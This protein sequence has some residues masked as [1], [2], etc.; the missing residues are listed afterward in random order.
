MSRGKFWKLAKRLWMVLRTLP[1]REKLIAIYCMTEQTNRVGLFH[2][3]S[4]KAAEDLGLSR[5]AFDTA[6]RRVCDELAWKF[7]SEACVLYLTDWW[8]YN[9]PG[10]KDALRAFLRD[11]LDIPE[12]LLL[13]EFLS[14]TSAL[15]PELQTIFHDAVEA[16]SLPHCPPPSPPGCPPP[17]PQGGG[18][19]RLN[20]TK[21]RQDRD[22][23]PPVVSVVNDGFE[24]FWKAYPRKDDRKDALKAWAKLAP[25]LEL[26]T[27]ILQA[28][29]RQAKSSQWLK[30]RGEFI[31]LPATWLNKRRWENSGVSLN[32]GGSAGSTLCMFQEQKGLKNGRL[33]I[34]GPCG[35]LIAAQEGVEKPRPLCEG[36]LKAERERLAPRPVGP[37][38]TV[39]TMTNGCGLLEKTSESKS[40]PQKTG[41]IESAGI[42]G[43]G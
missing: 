18:H 27:Q 32:N 35:R 23:T 41:A 16:L 10:N 7:D 14:Q 36:H 38:E 13:T 31:P 40:S 30:D 11:L 2:F 8:Q 26:Q 34:Y 22:R 6:F 4:A 17:G 39:L 37:I 28:V 15:S 1:E 9:D 19:T 24:T 33:P 12:T 20:E 29:D 21:T 3:S 25:N 42:T 43:A 5:R